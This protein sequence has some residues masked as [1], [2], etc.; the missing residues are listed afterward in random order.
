MKKHESRSSQTNN[1][2]RTTTR[3]RKSPANGET[4]RINHNEQREQETPPPSNSNAGLN[5]GKAEKKVEFMHRHDIS[6]KGA[7]DDN[8]TGYYVGEHIVVVA[9]KVKQSILVMTA[10]NL[11]HNYDDEIARLRFINTV[12]FPAK[13]TIISTDPE[14]YVR[15]TFDRRFY[16]RAEMLIDEL[17]VH[18]AGGIFE[19]RKPFGSTGVNDS[20]QWDCG[21]YFPQWTCRKILS[22]F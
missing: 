19:C 3:T 20:T 22:M 15:I 1:T 16:K 17:G 14:K 4:G 9:V 10:V 6:I 12:L 7:N 21:D 5:L 18:F 11:N 8:A 2:T 13:G